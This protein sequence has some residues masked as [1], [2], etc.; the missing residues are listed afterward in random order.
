MPTRYFAKLNTTNYKALR[1]LINE[2]PQ[3]F[4]EWESS[5]AVKKDEHVLMW[6]PNGICVDVE[7]DSNEFTAYCD[8]T[9]SNRTLETLDRLVAE[10]GMREG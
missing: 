9:Q 10:K 8:R 4:S 5:Q 7:I 3:S 1:S 6:H 2:L